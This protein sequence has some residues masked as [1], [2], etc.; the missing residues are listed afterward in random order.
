V[1][2]AGVAGVGSGWREDW[3]EAHTEAGGVHVEDWRSRCR[4]VPV[5]HAQTHIHGI[6]VGYGFAHLNLGKADKMRIITVLPIPIL[7]SFVV[8][9]VA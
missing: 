8:S 4:W 9:S 7:G 6:W 1:V 2:G 5:A 3:T